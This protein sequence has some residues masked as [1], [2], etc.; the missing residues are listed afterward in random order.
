MMTGVTEVLSDPAR[1]VEVELDPTPARKRSTVPWMGSEQP[2]RRELWYCWIARQPRWWSRARR[3]ARSALLD[4][5]PIG[6][7]LVEHREVV[8]RNGTSQYLMLVCGRLGVE[9]RCRAVSSLLELKRALERRDASVLNPHG[10]TSTRLPVFYGDPMELKAG[11][12]SW[13][14]THQLVGTLYNGYRIEERS[15]EY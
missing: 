9:L 5:G 12:W 7:T 4:R 8:V 11:V 6:E 1:H 15:W 2:S 10:G 13:D 3:E 14:R